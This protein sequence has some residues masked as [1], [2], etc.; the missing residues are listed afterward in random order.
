[1]TLKETTIPFTNEERD[2][3]VD[4][5]G[6]L[7]VVRAKSAFEAAAKLGKIQA[8]CGDIR[9]ASYSHDPEEDPCPD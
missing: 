8:E 7:H 4:I 9:Y 3:I 2:W 1:M 5:K 6:Q